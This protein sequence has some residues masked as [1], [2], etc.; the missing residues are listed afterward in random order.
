MRAFVINKFRGDPDV[1]A[2]GLAE[3]TRRTGV[4]FA[5]VLPWLDGVWLDAEDSLEVGALAAFVRRADARPAAGRGRPAAARL[6]RHRRRGPGR[7]TRRRGPR[8]HR[9]RGRRRRG[10]GRPA[11]D[12]GH[13]LRPGL[14]AAH[15]P[16]RRGPRPRA[17][18]GARPRDLRRLPDA[19]P[20]RR[21]PGRR[22]GGRGDRA[23]TASGCCRSSRGSPSRSRSAA[24]RELARA[25]GAGVR[26]PPRA[27]VAVAR[28][29]G[30][31]EPFLDGWRVGTTWG[32]VWHGAFENDGFRRAWLAEVAAAAGSSWTPTPGARVRGPARGD[33]RRA[34]RR[35][36]GAPR[37]RPAAGRHPR[38]VAAG[39][40]RVTV[41][42]LVV[43]IGSGDPAH[44]TGEAVAALNAV[45]VF[46]V[47]DKRAATRDLVTLRAELCAAVITHDRY[48]FVEVARP[49]ARAGRRA[50]LRPRTPGPSATGT[51]S[52]RAA[53]PRRSP[54]EV[55]AS[56]TVGLLVWGDP[57]L[58]DSTLRV[59]DTMA[60]C[61]RRP[62][63]RQLE[64]DVTVVPGIS[65]VSLL[66]ARHRRRA[67]P[68]RPARAHHDRPP[69]RRRV[70]RRARRRRRHARRRPGLRRAGRGAPRPGDLLGR[71]ARAARRG[72]RPRSAGR[73]AARDPRPGATPCAR[74]AAG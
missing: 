51:P 62:G 73:R 70:R 39:A 15:R 48:R 13:V 4:P 12:P 6:E 11:G 49:R 45:D 38:R 24:R 40:G 63:R 5:G 28:R 8:D 10:P 35:G 32:T 21:G 68:G 44:L 54:G 74:P 42:V 33:D 43:G 56:G 27:G 61:W 46:L 1:L 41:R 23:P 18:R 36:R 55:G 52:G 47:A 29:R 19:R 25:P 57:S 17:P 34:R 37:P 14:A 22:R 65:S 67:Q 58:Y 66:A 26:D 20:P 3:I 50:R 30:R 7:R 59:V 71:P 31:A 69:A 72:A 60:S 9:P 53:T 2:P 64:V 16:R